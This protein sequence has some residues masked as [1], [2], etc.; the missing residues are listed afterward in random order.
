M[1]GMGGVERTDGAE[2]GRCKV[3]RRTLTSLYCDP[4]RSRWSG[5]CVPKTRAEKTLARSPFLAP[6]C[7][8]ARAARSSHYA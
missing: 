7:P 5:V 1:S 4:V 8:P 2:R 6:R 3:A